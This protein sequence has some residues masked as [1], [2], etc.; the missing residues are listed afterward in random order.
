MGVLNWFFGSDGAID[1]A[2]ISAELERLAQLKERGVLSE[3]FPGLYGLPGAQSP[4]HRR[5]T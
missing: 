2:S 3:E 1:K 4:R 5:R